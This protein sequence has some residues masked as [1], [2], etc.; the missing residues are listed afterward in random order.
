MEQAETDQQSSE[1]A[2]ETSLSDT[3]LYQD[4]QT[5]SIYLNNVQQSDSE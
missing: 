1:P 4:K 2:A 5:Y 3:D